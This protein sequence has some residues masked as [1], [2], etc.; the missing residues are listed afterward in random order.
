ML[1]SNFKPALRNLFKNKTYS[2]LNIFGLAIGIACAGF[3]FLWVED[4]LNFDS[5]NLKKHRLYS[6][7]INANYEGN[8]NTMNS[9]PRPLAV[10]LKTE[11]P[12][13]VNAARVSEEDERLLFSIEDKP[14][15]ANGRYV[16]SS[17]FS[18]FTLPFVEGNAKAAFAKLYSIVLTE[19]SARKFF[20]AQ[21][22]LVGR[23]LRVNNK[24]DFIVS[25]V[26][27][28]LPENSTM[29]FEWLAPYDII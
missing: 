14:I 26:L 29:H 19:K 8:L 22:N 15:Y 28:D 2:I 24:Q 7:Q 17:L 13:I 1:A 5:Y 6:V 11:I 21:R 3:I 18:M 4:E 12:G 20:G 23:S 16:D 10:S 25:G 27:K 9:T